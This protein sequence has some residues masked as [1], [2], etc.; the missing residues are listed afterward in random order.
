[1][2]EADK[3]QLQDNAIE[4][5]QDLLKLSLRKGEVNQAQIVKAVA[6]ELAMAGARSTSQQL[7]P[8][9]QRLLDQIDNSDDRD[10]ANVARKILR[11]TKLA[12]YTHTDTTPLEYKDQPL[13]PPNK[14]N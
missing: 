5:L 13:F 8:T 14:V 2:K 9:S 6:A 10:V 12:A 4:G 7:S 1:M 3:I 11:G